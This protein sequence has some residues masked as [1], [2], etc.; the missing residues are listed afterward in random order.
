MRCKKVLK[1]TFFEICMDD[2]LSGWVTSHANEIGRKV[3]NVPLSG[4]GGVGHSYCSAL[5]RYREEDFAKMPGL[6]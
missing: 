6:T 3:K 5:A 1:I 4:G 2:N